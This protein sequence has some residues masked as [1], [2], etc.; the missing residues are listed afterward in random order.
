M[1]IKSYLCITNKRCKNLKFFETYVK[2]K[3]PKKGL[4]DRQK[5]IRKLMD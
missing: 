2:K 5:F 1:K 4:I 3:T